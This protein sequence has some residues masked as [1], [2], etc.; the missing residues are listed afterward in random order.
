MWAHLRSAAQTADSQ[1]WTVGSPFA[2][3]CAVLCCAVLCFALLLFSMPHALWRLRSHGRFGAWKYEVSNQDHSMMQGVEAADHALFGSVRS[4]PSSLLLV[5]PNRLF[6]AG[7]D[8]QL[9]VCG[10]RQAAERPHSAP[11]THSQ[12]NNR[13]RPP[14]IVLQSDPRVGCC[15]IAF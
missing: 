6:V 2:L 13:P 5:S 12:V 1:P 3:P 9:P 14:Q 10:Q 15:W 11:Q 4:Y 7:A 8:L